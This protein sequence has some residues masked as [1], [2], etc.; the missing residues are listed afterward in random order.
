MTNFDLDEVRDMIEQE[1]D[2]TYVESESESVVRFDMNDRSFWL[3]ANSKVDNLETFPMK[4][5]NRILQII[6]GD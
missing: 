1:F 5:R 3:Y 4:M 2:F 6:S